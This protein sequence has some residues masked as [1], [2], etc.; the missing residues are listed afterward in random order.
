VPAVTLYDLD[1]DGAV[2]ASP[3]YLGGFCPAQAGLGEQ[4]QQVGAAFLVRYRRDARIRRN[5]FAQNR[6]DHKGA[7]ERIY[8]R[9]SLVDFFSK[10]FLEGRDRYGLVVLV[11]HQ[12]AYLLLRDPHPDQ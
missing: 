3:L 11:A 4:R 7:D 1:N 12:G 2:F 6:V 5:R 8:F 10:M 9:R